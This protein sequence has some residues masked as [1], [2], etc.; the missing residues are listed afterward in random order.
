M[1]RNVRGIT[2]STRNKYTSFNAHD[3]NRVGDGDEKQH[4]EKRREGGVQESWGR[5]RDVGKWVEAWID[6]CGER[7]ASGAAT[8]TEEERA[9]GTQERESE[10][11][12]TEVANQWRHHL[13]AVHLLIHSSQVIP[14]SAAATGGK[15]KA[16]LCTAFMLPTSKWR[17][18]EQSS[19]A[20]VSATSSHPP[21][22][23]ADVSTWAEIYRPFDVNQ[24]INCGLWSIY[25][26]CV[27]VGCCCKSVPGLQLL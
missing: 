1:K 18:W 8:V 9:M 24:T 13:S 11:E 2:D 4:N 27:R 12:I 7:T 16:P 22:L 19:W 25:L 6:E 21:L 10:E 15:K 20:G 5:D 23:S 14:L 17:V 26:C 3:E